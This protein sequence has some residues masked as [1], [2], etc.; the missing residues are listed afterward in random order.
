MFKK[1]I[2]LVSAVLMSL[3]LLLVAFSGCDEDA[4]STTVRNTTAVGEVDKTPI[5]PTEKEGVTSSAV[6]TQ[7]GAVSTAPAVTLAPVT[8]VRVEDITVS[9]DY[10]ISGMPFKD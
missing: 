5:A 9:Y 4:V 6:T 3:I 7:N 1:K 2:F 8:A 10:P